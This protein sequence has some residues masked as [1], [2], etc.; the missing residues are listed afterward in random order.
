[1][2]QAPESPWQMRPT[3][4]EVDANAPDGARP[5]RREPTMLRTKPHC[6]T[7]TRPTRSASPPRTTIKMHENSAVMDTAMFITL[8]GIPRS[9]AIVD[10]IFSV[11]W[12]NSQ[13][14][15]TP[16]M[17]PNRS[18]S[19]PTYAAFASGLSVVEVVT[20]HLQLQFEA[21]HPGAALRRRRRRTVGTAAYN[22]QARA[23]TTIAAV[24][25]FSV[26]SMT[27]AKC[28]E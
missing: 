6:T 17:M 21:P 26:G 10:A 23:A 20:R 25:V 3:S 18:R 27:G 1:M 19:L 13:N 7:F 9:V 28:G 4:K 8:I 5:T 16:R 22:S 11:V 2:M 15:R 14:A 24:P 12:A